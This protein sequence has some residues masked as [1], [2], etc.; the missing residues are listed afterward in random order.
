M[1]ASIPFQR[2]LS[3]PAK[4]RLSKSDVPHFFA[5][6]ATDTSVLGTPGEDPEVLTVLCVVNLKATALWSKLVMVLTKKPSTK[7]LTIFLPFCSRT[8]VIWTF[9]SC[10]TEHT[11]QKLNTVS[12]TEPDSLSSNVPKPWISKLPMLMP[13]SELKIKMG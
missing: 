2:C 4:K 10:T 9:S 12:P 8:S 1:G 3:H 5:N 13:E 7:D 6:S 11:V